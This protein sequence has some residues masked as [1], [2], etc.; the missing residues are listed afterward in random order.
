VSV[1]TLYRISAGLPY[2]KDVFFV[3]PACLINFGKLNSTNM[4]NALIVIWLMATVSITAQEGEAGSAPV[5]NNELDSLSYFL[6][7]S[8]GYDFQSLPFDSDPDLIISGMTSALKGTAPFDQQQTRA[9]FQELQMAIQAREQEKASEAGMESIHKGEQFLEE[10]GAREG[11]VTLESGMQYEVLVKGDG[12][13]PTDTSEVEV[14]YEGSL[15]DGTV[16]DS[17]YERGESISFPLNRVIAGW[18]EGVQLMPVGSTYMLYIPSELGYGSRDSG[19][20]PPNSV[21]IFK[22]ELLGIK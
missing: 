19:P 18:T 1:L 9:T 11:V 10:N 7:L 21:L 5:L 14:H 22:I 3:L 8:L 13:M 12:P 20:I 2:Q 17:S 15:I 4:K 16:F 6:G